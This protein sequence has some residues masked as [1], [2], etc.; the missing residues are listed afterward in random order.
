M[1]QQ[2]EIWQD[3]SSSIARQRQLNII[4]GSSVRLGIRCAYNKGV[5]FLIEY[6]RTGKTAKSLVALCVLNW[7]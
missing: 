6:L 4:S 1:P 2:T 5:H 7:F 3:S